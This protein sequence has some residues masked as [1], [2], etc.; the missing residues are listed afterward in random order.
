MLKRIS[1]YLILAVA[2][3]MITAESCEMDIPMLKVYP[4]PSTDILNVEMSDEM[5]EIMK[6]EGE[7]LPIFS[8]IEI[9][10][11]QTGKQMKEIF[12]PSK[13]IDVSFLKPGAYTI[14]VFS[15]GE[16]IGNSKFLKE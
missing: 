3:L 4:N 2:F 10:S 15:N 13:R 1:V 14:V 11:L 16:L 8:K 12:N 6:S 5:V 9:Y 7:P